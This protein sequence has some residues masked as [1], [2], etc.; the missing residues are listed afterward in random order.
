[1][2]THDNMTC[3]VHDMY[4]YM[5]MCMYMLTCSVTS[6]LRTCGGSDV[7]FSCRHSEESMAFSSGEICTR[8]ARAQ[9][10]AQASQERLRASLPSARGRGGLRGRDLPGGNGAMAQ[11]GRFGAGAPWDAQR[12]GLEAMGACDEGEVEGTPVAGITDPAA[13]P[14]L[15]RRTGGRGDGWTS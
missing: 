15:L 1:M 5:C 11:V 4:M 2:L 10:P 9:G 12:R 3:H 6:D 7:A 13:R 14:R 8:V